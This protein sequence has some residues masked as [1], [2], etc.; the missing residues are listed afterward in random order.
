MCSYILINTQNIIKMH[1]LLKD[2]MSIVHFISSKVHVIDKIF[3]PFDA[4]SSSKIQVWV[5]TIRISGPHDANCSEELMLDVKGHSYLL[6]VSIDLENWFDEMNT[7]KLLNSMILFAAL[8]M[9]YV[10]GYYSDY[11][12]RPSFSFSYKVIIQSC[13]LK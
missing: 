1:V 4:N 13:Y 10:L 5:N 8:C 7:I 12:R 2:F 9:F 6:L 11:A 3:F